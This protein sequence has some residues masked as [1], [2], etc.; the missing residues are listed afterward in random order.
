MCF[1]WPTLQVSTLCYAFYTRP[2]EP[3]L[4]PAVISTC[5]VK[6]SSGQLTACAF[7]DYDEEQ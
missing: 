6:V 2:F 1:E 4:R 7:S 5:Y 3:P